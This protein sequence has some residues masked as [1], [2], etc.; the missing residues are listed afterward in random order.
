[1][2]S[3]CLVALIQLKYVCVLVEWY[4]EDE[5]GQ[6]IRNTE[7]N[8]PEDLV[9]VTKVHPRSYELNAMRVSLQKS[10]MDLYGEAKKLDVV[11]LHAPFC[12]EGHCNDEQAE[13]IHSGG[14]HAAWR[15]LE[16][17]HDEGLVAA[18]GVSNFHPNQLIELLSFVANKRVAVVQNFMVRC[19]IFI[20]DYVRIH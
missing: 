16:Q 8:A 11:L 4:R 15:N 5:V 2:Y 19:E 14:W 7:C 20:T 3:V 13:F 10:Q 17:M 6:A 18:I 1:M 9:V 12:W